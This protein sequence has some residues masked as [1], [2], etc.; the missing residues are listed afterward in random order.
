MAILGKQIMPPQKPVLMH[1]PR[2]HLKN[3]ASLEFVATQYNQ[4]FN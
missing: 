4:V 3:W 1:L 2:A